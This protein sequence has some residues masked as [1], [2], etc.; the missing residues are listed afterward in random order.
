MTTISILQIDI[1]VGV[2]GDCKLCPVGLAGART[3]WVLG[4]DCVTVGSDAINFIDRPN[5]RS[6][7]RLLPLSVIAFI[8]RFDND[9]FKA[10]K[11]NMLGESKQ[12]LAPF[13]PFE[14]KI[15]DVPHAKELKEND[16][17]RR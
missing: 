6:A 16:Y 5:S 7:T 1:D 2:Q 10:A 14:F 12:P 8:S 17:G 13:A 9:N 3:G 4:Y 15:E 11:V